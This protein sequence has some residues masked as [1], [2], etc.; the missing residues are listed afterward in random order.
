MTISYGT[1]AI[2]VTATN[3]HLQG[4]SLKEVQN[5]VRSHNTL[6]CF[7]KLPSDFFLS[8]RTRGGGRHAV[9]HGLWLWEFFAEQPP[10]PEPVRVH[11]KITTA[12]ESR[13]SLALS[14]VDVGSDGTALH[15]P[16]AIAR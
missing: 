1:I 5:A 15:T 13:Q 9:M 2:A 16:N 3:T 7:R 4:C 12:A 11:K 10:E 14:S 8:G 6:E